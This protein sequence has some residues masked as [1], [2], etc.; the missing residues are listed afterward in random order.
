MPVRELNVSLIATIPLAQGV[1][2]GKYRSGKE[3]PS[4]FQRTIAQLTR[5]DWFGEMNGKESFFKRL[6]TTPRSLQREQLE[7]V[8]K[9]L[10]EIAKAHG[11][12]IPQVAVNWLMTTDPCVIPIPGAKN[13]RQAGENAGALGWRLTKEEYQRISQTEIASR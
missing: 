11:K 1:L 5:I 4:L 13:A 7:P 10:E 2:T 6:F 3:L 12:T 8:F 9:V